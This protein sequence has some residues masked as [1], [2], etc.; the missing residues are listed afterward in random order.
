MNSTVR[1]LPALLFTVFLLLIPFQETLGNRLFGIFYQESS[2]N[3][4]SQDEIAFLER[5]GI[6]WLLVEEAVSGHQREVLM[7]SDISLL[8]MVP[9][10]YPIPHRLTVEKYNY[11]QRSDSLMHIYRDDGLVRGFGLFAYGTWQKGSLP[12]KLEQLAEPYRGNRT[13]FTLDLRPLSGQALR[14]F[15]SVLM[16]T[17]SASQLALQ[18]EHD[19]TLA[20]VLYA[21]EDPVL[22]LRDFQKV[23]ELLD[24]HGD[25]PVFFTRSWFAANSMYAGHEPELNLAQITRYFHQVPDARIANPPSRDS[26]YEVNLAMFLLFFFWVIYA[27]FFR[28]N[29][30]Y[31]SSVTR[32]FLNYDFFVS[33][34]LMRRIRF[35]WDAAAVFFFSCLISGVM[36]FSI[37]ELYLDP[38]ARQALLH[39]TPFLASGWGHSAV[40]FIL[41]FLVMAIMLSVMIAWLFIANSHHAH[42]SQIATFILW[43]QHLNILVASAGIIFLRSFPGASTVIIMIGF[44]LFVTVISFF[45]AAYNMRRIHP[46]SP[47]YMSTTYA[48]FVLVAASVASWLIFGMDLLKAWE[49]ASSLTILQ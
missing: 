38:V 16:M 4:L 41:F 7:K 17:R 9:E 3:H 42:A 40:F 37:A 43:P 26:E 48:L 8:V 35:T 18:L 47:L 2:V 32:F 46:T 10:Y 22:D 15:D 39:Y 21:P 44:F 13:L 29:P 5:A 6:Q 45:T 28:I 19:P 11:R 34:V 25:I 33:D 27:V 31:R 36:G 14:P 24:G 30:L 49:L 23:L 1:I 12:A 20:G